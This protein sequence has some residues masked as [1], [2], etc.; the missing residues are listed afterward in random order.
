MSTSKP[1]ILNVRIER[2]VDVDPDLSYLGAYGNHAETEWAVDR[3][4]RRDMERNEYRYW[5]PCN[6]VPPGKPENWAHVSD[7]DVWQAVRTTGATM[8]DGTIPSGRPSA[9]VALDLAYIV[10][11]YQRHESY[12]NQNWCCLGIIAKAKVQ[13]ADGSLMQTIRS[14]GLWG[15]ESD[16]G[17]E[18][19]AFVEH[20]EL[21][22]LGSELTAMGFSKRQIDY[23]VKH[24]ERKFEK[25]NQ[26]ATV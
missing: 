7:E 10:Q 14:G 13:L 2:V 3:E 15:I 26:E 11:D 6:H 17:D 12:N 8:P 21:A 23:A 25:G 5:N 9:L 1:K 16:S 22:Q 20:D 24:V 18:Y 4:E 19:F